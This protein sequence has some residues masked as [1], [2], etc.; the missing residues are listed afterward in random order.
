[1]GKLVILQLLEGDFQRGF[2]C[3]VQIGLD[4]GTL[5]TRAQITGR[6]PANPDMPQKL[7]DEWR[8]VF[9]FDERSRIKAKQAGVTNC[10]HTNTVNN[11]VKYL[12]NWLNNSTDSEWQKIRD[13]LQQSLNNEEEIRVIIQTQD[14][15]LRRIPWQA[16][17]LFADNYPR[18]EIA[19]GPTNFATPGDLPASNSN[20]V[21]ILVVLGSSTVADGSKEIDITFDQQ[22][23]EKLK[24]LGAFLKFLE[25]PDPQEL[26]DYLWLEEGWDIFFFAGHSSSSDDGQDGEIILNELAQGLKITELFE[27]LKKAISRGLQLAIF[28]SC[29]GL[30]LAK[31]LAE[32]NIRSLI[33]MRELVPDAVAKT[34]LKHFLT[35]LACNNQSM[36]PQLLV[37]HPA[38]VEHI[39]SKLICLIVA[40]VLVTTELGF[41]DGKRIF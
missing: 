6:L 5:E 31:Q 15:I 8:S 36:T 41:L 30:G 12:N 32:L 34:F 21:R 19:L 26:R 14:S 28:N 2:S 3:T 27:A 29:D 16:W 35:A 1:M 13:F 10:S 33:V 20:K 11:F 23:L 24:Q 17:N 4:G 22:E 40:L 38:E 39:K 37:S 25:Q 18:A 7:N 9:N